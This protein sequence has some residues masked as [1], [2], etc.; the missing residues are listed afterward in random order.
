LPPLEHPAGTS[1]A[2][3]KVLVVDDDFRNIFNEER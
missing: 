2:G 1:L 3:M